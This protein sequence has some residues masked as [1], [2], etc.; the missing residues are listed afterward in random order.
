MSS[1]ESAL[2]RV[3]TRQRLYGRG[4]KPVRRLEEGATRSRAEREPTRMVII[5]S[6]S[7]SD[8][9]VTGFRQNR[10]NKVLPHRQVTEPKM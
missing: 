2:V 4:G 1:L 6:L 5:A 3:T 9:L 8:V 7:K 10:T